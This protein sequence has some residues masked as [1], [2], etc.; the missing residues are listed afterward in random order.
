MDAG[1][2]PPYSCLSGICT[3]CRAKLHSG[4]IEM[5]EREGL[6]DSEIENGFILT[7]QSHP[8]SD[9]VFFEFDYPLIFIKSYIFPSFFLTFNYTKRIVL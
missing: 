4:K 6:S 2:D 3:T 5:D 9:D 8:L 7:C 1:Y